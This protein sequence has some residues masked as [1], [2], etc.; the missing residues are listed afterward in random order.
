[1][2]GC[3]EH[4]L[5]ALDTAEH[6]EFVEHEG[7]EVLIEN[8]EGGRFLLLDEEHEVVLLTDNKYDAAE[9]I[10]LGKWIPYEEER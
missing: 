10:M 8:M 4:L 3:L 1:M 9:F 6:G 5:S 2:L 7:R